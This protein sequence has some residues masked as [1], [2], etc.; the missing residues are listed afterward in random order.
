M[1]E[2]F[3]QPVNLAGRTLNSDEFYKW[4]HGIPYFYKANLMDANLQG[5]NAYAPYFYEAN[6]MD[7]DLSGVSYNKADFTSAG[8]VQSNFEGAVLTDVIFQSANL[9]RANFRKCTF[10]GRVNLIETFCHATKFIETNM[11][12]Y[13]LPNKKDRPESEK[14]IFY[15]ADFSGSSISGSFL[16]VDFRHANFHNTKLKGHFVGCDFRGANFEGTDVSE[17]TLGSY[18]AWYGAMRGLP[19]SI[20]RAVASSLRNAPWRVKE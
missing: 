18:D 1:E 9:R 20:K 15:E 3:S 5:S 13:T 8:L 17:M 10:V 14:L 2:Y 6:L 16:G 4:D 19:R 12:V 11:N 7:A